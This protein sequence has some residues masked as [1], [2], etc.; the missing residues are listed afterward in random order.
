MP[1]VRQVGFRID[2]VPGAAPVAKAPYR[3]TPPEMKELHSHLQE[4]SNKGFIYAEYFSFP[5]CTI[6][7]FYFEWNS[8]LYII[9]NQAR[10][11]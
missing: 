10:I 6:T 8:R 1:P 11:F 2:L 9:V 7:L 5:S 4:L 3:L